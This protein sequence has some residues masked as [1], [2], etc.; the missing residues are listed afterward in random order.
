MK[1]RLDISPSRSLVIDAPTQEAA[2]MAAARWVR[3]HGWRMDGE[4]ILSRLSKD[5][6]QEAA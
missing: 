2:Q 6:E 5:Q 1:W 3:E 4:Q